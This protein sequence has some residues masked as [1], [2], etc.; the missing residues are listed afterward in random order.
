M[1]R[2]HGMGIPV[3]GGFGLVTRP[4]RLWQKVQQAAVRLGRGQQKV[5]VMGNQF[6]GQAFYIHRF[7]PQG[8]HQLQ[9]AVHLPISRGAA[10]RKQ[11]A[12]VGHPGHAAHQLLVHRPAKGGAGVQQA[13]GIPHRAVPQH[14]HQPRRTLA[15]GNAL[16]PGHLQEARLHLFG[17]DAG[18]VEALAAGEDGGGHL[19]QL[20]GGQDENN[21]AG[22][23]LQNF[24]QRVEGRRGEHM[25]L[26][27]DIH[28]VAAAPRA[29]HRL[30]A[31]IPH[32]VH[33]VV[34][35]CVNLYHIQNAAVLDA[36]TAGADAAGAVFT[37]VFTVYGFGQH[38]GTGGF[39]GAAGAG[40]QVGMAHPPGLHLA[41]KRAGNGLLPHH[42]AEG[43]G[44]PLAVQRLIH[45]LPLP[46]KNAPKCRKKTGSTAAL[47]TKGRL[48]AAH[49]RIRLMLLGSPP[50]MVHGVPL[51]RTRLPYAKQR[52]YALSFSAAGA[53][54]HA[55]SKTNL[56]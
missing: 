11:I 12:L 2:P 23:F 20:G 9:Q 34:R 38:L 55:A 7:F 36:G 51:H 13:Q 31:Q 29:V 33:A 47:H 49:R 28:L 8:G 5:T 40:E 53:W 4:L 30:I 45:G 37:G 15:E 19:V 44:P 16:L 3:F 10:E 50:D 48:A 25:H 46:S 43:F 24:Q 52:E 35:G 18:K 6:L 41:G 1:Q 14:G 22:R 32:I 54:P 17:R 42:V 21:V 56:L 39:A 27:D 26:V